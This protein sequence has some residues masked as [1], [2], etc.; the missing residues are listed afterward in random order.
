[1]S[2][3][4]LGILV[5]QIDDGDHL[6]LAAQHIKVLREPD[7]I[8]LAQ[9]ES[10]PHRKIIVGAKCSNCLVEILIVAMLSHDYFWR[11]FNRVGVGIV[12]LEHEVVDVL[13]LFALKHE[14][15]VE[16][17]SIRDV[18]L[19]LEQILGLAVME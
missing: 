7:H 16:L 1:V 4:G 5:V 8:L 15:E 2:A 18:V 12:D 3:P 14:A 11:K 19:L 10:V 13:V 9:V 6:G 17:V